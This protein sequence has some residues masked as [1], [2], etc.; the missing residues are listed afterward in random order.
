MLQR[1]DWVTPI[2]NDQLRH[3]KPALLYWLIMSAYGAFGVNEFAA[4]FWSALLGVG[5]VLL[6]SLIGTRLYGRATG[7]WSGLL[8]ATMLMFGV[9]SRAATP[10]APLIFFMTA[11]IACFVWFAFRPGSSEG[12]EA[13]FRGFPPEKIG[14]AHI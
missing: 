14:R 9:A 13:T 3:Q 12:E 10:D 7:F 5:T 8:L 6:T 1:G 4:R 2:F 11:G